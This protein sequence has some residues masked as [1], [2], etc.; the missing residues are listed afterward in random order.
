MKNSWNTIY[1]NILILFYIL[2][3]LSGEK[4]DKPVKE[5]ANAPEISESLVNE[6]KQSTLAMFEATVK[7]AHKN[8]K[9]F[10]S[11]NEYLMV[12]Y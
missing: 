11:S 2:T 3:F 8:S 5:E 6:I 9:D 1:H 10:S 7:D 4:G 12:T